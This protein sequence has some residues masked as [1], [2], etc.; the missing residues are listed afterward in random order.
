MRCFFLLI[1]LVST[2]TLA[3]TPDNSPCTV[4]IKDESKEFSESLIKTANSKKHIIGYVHS[5]ADRNAVFQILKAFDAGAK[6]LDVN[7]DSLSP[8]EAILKTLKFGGNSDIIKQTLGHVKSIKSKIENGEIQKVLVEYPA[9][10]DVENL[11]SEISSAKVR[12]A[13][14]G[15]SAEEIENTLALVFG[16]VR[17]LMAEFSPKIK[18][19]RA[20]NDPEII[21][22]AAND[23]R[24]FKSIA[25]VFARD[26][27]PLL[28]EVLSLG[29]LVSADSQTKDSIEMRLVPLLNRIGSA[30]TELR[31]GAQ[32]QRVPLKTLV[33][34]Y[35]DSLLEF[36]KHREQR[37][38]IM[39]EAT[40]NAST[41]TLLLVGNAHALATMEAYKAS[42]EVSSAAAVPSQNRV[43]PAV[44]R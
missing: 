19:E 3:K 28:K 34:S 37:N 2:V 1:L 29:E 9:L 12:L 4:T 5:G 38:K 18:F 17:L 15:L 10:G 25:A 6:K 33:Q 44:G 11:K 22:K 41:N 27:N 23:Q 8:K 30:T 36:N 35:I 7:G 21:E 20:E 39:L 32:T 43:A 16:P 24:T 26:T 42:C 31:N 13:A 14:V 40:Q